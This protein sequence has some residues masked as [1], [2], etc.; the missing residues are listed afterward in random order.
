MP[1][2]IRAAVLA[3]VSL[4]ACGGGNGYPTG[5]GGQDP[6][7]GGQQPPSTSNAVAVQNNRFSPAAT[8]VAA[9]TTV[10]WTWDSCDDDGYGG[11]VC[12][13]H[14]VTFD[15][16]GGGSARQSTGSYQRQFNTAGTFNY[17][18]TLHGAAMTG[19]VVV[20]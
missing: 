14:S 16:A 8:T 4:A 7:P 17:R 20:R 15:G 18:C 19:Q 10:T 5:S 9:G 13:E 1:A 6:P 12:V 3:L 11:R 2:V